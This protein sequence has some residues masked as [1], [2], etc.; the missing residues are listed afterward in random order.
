MLVP[1]LEVAV[2]FL[3]SGKLSSCD[4]VSGLISCT[5]QKDQLACLWH[6]TEVSTL[7]SGT[8]R[9][10][11]HCQHSLGFLPPSW[12]LYFTE[13]SRNATALGRLFSL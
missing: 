4:T 10:V 8:V 1:V 6:C 3:Q 12:P 5:S 13:P 11:E 9:S 2:K 7:T